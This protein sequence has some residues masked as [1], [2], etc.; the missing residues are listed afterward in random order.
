MDPLISS[1]IQQQQ[2]QTALQVSMS[3][4]QKNAEVQKN[5]GEMVVGLIQS[6][7]TQTPGKTVGLGGSFDAFA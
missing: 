1:I 2:E 5:I 3:V 7:T 6:A 4:L